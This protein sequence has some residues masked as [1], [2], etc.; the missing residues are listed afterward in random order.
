MEIYIATE[1]ALSEAVAERLIEHENQG[2]FVAVRVGR[3]GNSYLRNNL[4]SYVNIARTIPLLLLTDLDKGACPSKLVGLWCGRK[5]LPQRMLFRV[6]VCEIEA[7]LL[8]DRKGFAAFSGVPIHRIPIH[9][10]SL[11]DPKE[12]LINL[13]RRYGKKS[14]KDDILPRRNSTARIGLAYNPLLCGFVQKTWSPI[15]AAEAADS[16]RRTM[17]RIHELRMLEVP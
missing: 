11:Q 2:M 5:K 4:L 15:M 7:W 17:R 6:V 9:P 14:V 3:R 8:A 12:T 10:E 1:D 16:L 13:V